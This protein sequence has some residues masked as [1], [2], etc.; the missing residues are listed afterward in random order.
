MILSVQSIMQTD[1]Q[2][3]GPRQSLA[4]LQEILLRADLGGL[5]VVKSG[6]IL[7]MVSRSDVVQRLQS[8]RELAMRKIGL[9]P[10]VHLTSEDAADLGDVIGERLE[11]IRVEQVMTREIFSVSPSDSVQSAA[12]LLTSNHIHRL[13]VVEHDHLVGMVT[14][15]DIVRLVADGTFSDVASKH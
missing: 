3:I 7:G 1:V 6:Q 13:P 5:P 10:E 4:K 14:G 11:K 15:H 2:T 8:E 9:P 12:E